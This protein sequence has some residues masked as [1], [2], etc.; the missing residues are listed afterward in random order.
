LV[1]S[2]LFCIVGSP[3]SVRQKIREARKPLPVRRGRGKA[4]IES[5]IQYKIFPDRIRNGPQIPNGISAGEGLREV[6]EFACDCQ[7]SQWM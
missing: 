5:G 1:A 4:I 7:P 3:Q 6:P 2:Y